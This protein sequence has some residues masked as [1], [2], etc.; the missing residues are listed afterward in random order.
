MCKVLANTNASVKNDVIK[1]LTFLLLPERHQ[2][3][4]DELHVLIQRLAMVITNMNSLK[5][6]FLEY[7]A[8]PDDEFPAYFDEDEKPMRINHIWHQISK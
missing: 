4:L 5:S 3:T 6:G 1:S 7:Q 8:T 2:A